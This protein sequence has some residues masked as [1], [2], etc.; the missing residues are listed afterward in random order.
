MSINV[1]MRSATKR[2][3]LLQAPSSAAAVTAQA[4]DPTERQAGD[5]DGVPYLLA[6]QA[7]GDL[8]S[9]PAGWSIIDQRGVNTIDVSTILPEITNPI[10]AF[11][12]G[13]YVERTA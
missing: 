7:T 3:L 4:A 6:V 12:L 1:E 9:V 13:R 2:V 10:V 11:L 8:P 5:V